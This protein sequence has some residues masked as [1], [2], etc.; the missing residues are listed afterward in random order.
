MREPPDRRV[1]IVPEMDCQGTNTARP[2]A[3][4]P[5]AFQLQGVRSDAYHAHR[6]GNW[7]WFNV[8]V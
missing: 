8:P 3:T 2:A 4:L 6:N 7:R 5:F 1:T